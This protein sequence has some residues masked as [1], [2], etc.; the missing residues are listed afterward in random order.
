MKNR[1]IFFEATLL[2]CVML[3]SFQPLCAQDEKELDKKLQSF[4]FDLSFYVDIDVIRTELNANPNFKAY[5]DS[6]RD[7]RK[8]IVGTIAKN[9]NLNPLTSGNQLIVLYSGGKKKKKVSFKWSIQ[10]KNEDLPSA[11]VDFETL[12]NDFKPL[13]SEAIEKF[14]VGQQNEQ[15]K[16]LL[17][18]TG[19]K[20]LV[21]KII[22]FNNFIHTVSIEYKDKWRI[23]PIDIIKVK[24]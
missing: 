19:T 8:S 21:I 14:G 7:A 1:L 16:S 6:N 9:K 12:K 5:Q 23:T 10:Y 11:S 15:V 3:M 13:F 2:T 24:Y 18:R 20:T 4:F 17:L 22:L